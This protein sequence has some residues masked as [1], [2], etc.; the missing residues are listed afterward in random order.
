MTPEE[1]SAK[2]RA[3]LATPEAGKVIAEAMRRAEESKRKLDEFRRLDD[4]VLRR[5]MT[6]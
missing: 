4:D 1:V 5:H 6:I 2:I 3:W